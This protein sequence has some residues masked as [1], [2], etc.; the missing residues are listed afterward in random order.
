MTEPTVLESQLSKYIPRPPRRG[1]GTGSRALPTILSRHGGNYTV[2]GSPTT[3]KFGQNANFPA[4]LLPNYSNGIEA[5]F[6]S[7]ISEMAK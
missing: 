5:G 1:L 2:L 4:R 3:P 6:D 7:M